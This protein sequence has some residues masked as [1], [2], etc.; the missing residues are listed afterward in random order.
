MSLVGALD[1][2][3]A[4]EIGL[5]LDDALA[6]AAFVVLDLDELASADP[7]GVAMLH[8]AGRVGGDRLIV[9]NVPPQ[10]QASLT[11]MGDPRLKLVS[12]A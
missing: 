8:A 10:V 12:A 9:V 11:T 2:L 5:M 1:R 6:D 7:A 3:A 4:P